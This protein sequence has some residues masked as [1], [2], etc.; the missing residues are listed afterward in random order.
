MDNENDAPQPES[1]TPLGKVLAAR[2][3]RR[4]MSAR[5]VQRRGGP[6]A[7]TINRLISTDPRVNRNPPS[8]GNLRKLAQVLVI[9]LPHLERA[10]DETRGRLPARPPLQDQ[11]ELMA[12][13]IAGLDPA[14]QE[15]IAE[16]VVLVTDLLR[17]AQEARAEVSAQFNKWDSDEGVTPSS[18]PAD[19]AAQR[20]ASPTCPTE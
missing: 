17:G 8:D 10:A 13:A 4:N 1:M 9:P 6:A 11:V 5:E 7:S 3:E 19:Q 20:L 15:A 14:Q 2:M 16:V 12:A 18:T